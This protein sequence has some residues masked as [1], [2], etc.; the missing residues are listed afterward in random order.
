VDDVKG[1][2]DLTPFRQRFAGN[3]KD[4]AAAFDQAA[5]DLVK[6]VFREASLR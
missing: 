3:D 1:G 2:V 5:A 4:V 6:L